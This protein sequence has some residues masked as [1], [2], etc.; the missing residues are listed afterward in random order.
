MRRRIRQAFRYDIHTPKATGSDEA[1]LPQ[2]PP[3]GEDF[4][5]Y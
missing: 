2:F 1:I 4:W 5:L 3:G